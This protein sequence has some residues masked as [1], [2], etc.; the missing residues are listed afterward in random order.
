VLYLQGFTNAK[1]AN[2]YQSTLLRYTLVFGLLLSGVL[3]YVAHFNLK[4]NTW[5]FLSAR[6]GRAGV[7]RF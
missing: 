2:P 1:N 4:R 5:L 6:L 7:Y 3:F